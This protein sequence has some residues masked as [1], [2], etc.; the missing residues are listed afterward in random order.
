MYVYWEFGN[1]PVTVIADD[2][3]GSRDSDAPLL[4]LR[5]R[6]RFGPIAFKDLYP[7]V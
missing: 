4:S 1:P 6:Y 5:E 2:P 7:L 3:I